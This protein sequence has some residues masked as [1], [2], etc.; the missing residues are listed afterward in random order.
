VFLIRPDVCEQ[1]RGYNRWLEDYCLSELF[2]AFLAE[3]SMASRWCISGKNNIMCYL[4]K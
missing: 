1:N 2:L 4:C 3:N